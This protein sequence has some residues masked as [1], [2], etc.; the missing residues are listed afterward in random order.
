MWL[1]NIP[2]VLI[3]LWQA[4]RARHPFFFTTANPTIPT[5][6][7]LGESKWEILRAI[8]KAYLPAT[9]LIQTGTSAQ[10]LRQQLAEAGIGFPA[11]AKPDIGERGR[12]VV[13]VH[14][15]GELWQY[16]RHMHVPYLVQAFVDAPEEY[17]I[18]YW[19][20]PEQSCGQITS[21]CIK[22]YL[23][24]K[25][26]GRRS[27]A[28]L[29]AHNPRASLQLNRMQQQKPQLMQYVPRHGEE[30]LIEPIGNHCRGA[31]FLNGNHLIDDQLTA[32]FDRISLAMQ[33]MYYGRFDLKCRSIESLRQGQFKILEFNGIAGEPAHIYD[34]SIPLY[35]KYYTIWQHWQILLRIYRVQ[36]KR[37]VA[38]MSASEFWQYVNR[39]L[40]YKCATDELTD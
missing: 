31:M 21:L 33:H 37:G 28:E 23:S 29:M 35:K 26:D 25:G 11:I 32:V 20:L 30:V 6:G 2:V 8:P 16:H 3:W 38:P 14:H 13:K 39:Y 27:V 15:F 1:I 10:Q 19:R 24:V 34:P 5:G 9:T 22:K 18:L 12:C 4:L 7:L 40:A 17:A 36:Q